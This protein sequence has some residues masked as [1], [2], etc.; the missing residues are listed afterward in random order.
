MLDRLILALL[1]QPVSADLHISDTQLGLLFGLG[2]GVLY[3]IAGLPL[4]HMLD[5]S[6]RIRLL[7]VGV[8]L[9]SLATLASAFAPGF[10]ELAFCRAGVAI[11]EAVLSPAAVSLLA[12]MFPREK[13]AAPTAA[14]TAVAAGMSS[15]AFVLGG[16]A[17]QAAGFLS[18]VYGMAPWRITLILVGAPGL[19]IALLMFFTVREPV[20]VRQANTQSYA[21]VSNALAYIRSEAR[22]YGCLFVGIGAYTIVAY[23]FIA[24]TPTL[25]IRKFGLTPSDAGYLFGL[26]GVTFGLGST[27]L[28][29][30]LVTRWTARGKPERLVT[31]M[32][33]SLAASAAAMILLG[34]SHNVSVASAA[35]ALIFLGGTTVSCLPPLIIHGQLFAPALHGRGNGGDG[36]RHDG[37]SGVPVGCRP[38]QAGTR[39]SEPRAGHQLRNGDVGH[40]PYD[41]FDARDRRRRLPCPVRI[42][43]DQLVRDGRSTLHPRIWILTRG[44]GERR[45]QESRP[46]RP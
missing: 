36:Q 22:L 19:L 38:D 17:F 43:A 30:W 25:L 2:F 3:A 39:T 20:R 5:R 29:P 34:F 44:A 9:W 21:T 10:T 45:R 35:I 1:A 24:W 8:M 40:R 23:T 32:G 14:F 12:D 46:R 31:A 26:I 15:G 42:Y 41:E 28:W 11:G 7:C 13:R 4:A 27:A 33:Y 6:H 16:W 18:P 37:R